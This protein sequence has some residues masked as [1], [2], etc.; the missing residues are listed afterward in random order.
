[1][2]TTAIAHGR[3]ARLRVSASVE[4]R[5]ADRGAVG[6]R[7]RVPEAHTR[8]RLGSGGQQRRDG[9]RDGDGEA[10]QPALRAYSTVTVF[11]R[12]RGWSTFSPRRRAIR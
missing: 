12:L 6:R 7:R 4:S 2:W 3:Y 1:M 11:A 8:R 9:E 10:A 5:G